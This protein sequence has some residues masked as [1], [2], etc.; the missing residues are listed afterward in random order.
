M[1]LEKKKKNL[2]MVKKKPKKWMPAAPCGPTA[3]SPDLT[4]PRT[5]LPP[6][7][8]LLLPPLLPSL[9]LAA[10]LLPLTWA[11][12][13]AAQQADQQR[14]PWNWALNGKATVDYMPA[15]AGK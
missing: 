3:S 2:N 12:F 11:G 13:A 15:V 9:P 7:L 10:P 8:L 14:L 4:T 6:P 5:L 1:K